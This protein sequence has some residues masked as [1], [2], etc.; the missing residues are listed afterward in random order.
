MLSFRSLAT[1]P[2]RR[3]SAR[4]LST[5][6]VRAAQA[7]PGSYHVVGH[8][9]EVPNDPDTHVP[10]E[11]YRGLTAHDILKETGQARTDNKLRHFTG[12]CLHQAHLFSA[13]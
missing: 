2:L 9:P 7:A 6:P 3:L 8:D 1:R 10:V 4:A 11:D 13:N 5:P 12:S